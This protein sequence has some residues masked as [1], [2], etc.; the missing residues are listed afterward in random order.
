PIN[1]G[2]GVDLSIRETAEL[3]R[4]VV[5]YPGELLFD[6]T[7]PDGMPLKSLDSTPLRRM[8][9]QPRTPIINALTETYEAF[10]DRYRKL[11]QE[12]T[13]VRAAV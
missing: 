12:G 9:W 11:Q 4:N 5:G 2:C 13:H 6:S 3:I 8:G 7:K 10:L 1:L